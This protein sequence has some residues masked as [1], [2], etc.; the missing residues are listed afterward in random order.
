MN[1]LLHDFKF[2]SRLLAKSPSYTGIS[3]LVLVIGLALYLCVY[4]L[5]YNFEFKPLPFEGGDRFVGITTIAEQTDTGYFGNNFDGYAFNYF[6]ERLTTFEH[7]GAFDME[8]TALTDGDYARW[9]IGARIMPHLLQE[10]GVQPFMGRLLSEEDAIPGAKPVALLRYNIWKNYFAADPNIIG[11]TTSIGGIRHTIVGVMPKGFDYPNSLQVWLPLDI[12]N[13]PEPTAPTLHVIGKIKEGVSLTDANKELN[14]ILS[15]LI[16]EYPE[17]YVH[18]PTAEAISLPQAVMGSSGIRDLMSIVANFTLALAI[19]NLA[20]LLFVRALT[21]EKELAVRSAV[22]ASGFQIAKQIL[23]E[24]LLICMLG[25]VLSAVIADVALYY[26]ERVLTDLYNT[27]GVTNGLPSYVD[28]TIDWRAFLIAVSTTG[29][30][31]LAS[32]LWVAYRA[33]RIDSNSVL[34]ANGKGSNQPVNNWLVRAIIS[35]DVTVSCFL[36]IVCCLLVF[37]IV[38]SYQNDYGTSVENYFTAF[39]TLS[40]ERYPEAEQRLRFLENFHNELSYQAEFE[41]VTFTTTPPGRRGMQ[42]SFS[43]EDRDVSV[44]QHSPSNALVAIAPN[45]F[46]SLEIELLEG[47]SFSNGDDKNSLPVAII[48]EM[49]ANRLWPNESVLG[50]KLQLKLNGQEFSVTLV[51]TA[52]HAAQG[53]PYGEYDLKFPIVY[54]PIKQFTRNRFTVAVKLK[55]SVSYIQA[56]RALRESLKRLDREIALQA[57]LPLEFFTRFQLSFMTIP[58]QFAVAF[59]IATL[60]FAVIGIYGLIARSVMLRTTEVGVRKAVGATKLKILWIFIRQGLIYISLGVVIGG[61]AALIASN[62][63]TEYFTD[64][65]SEA[66]LAFTTVTLVIGALVLLASYLPARKAL[67]LEPGDALRDE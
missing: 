18:A 10:T 47:R 59:V 15:E 33:A 38:R 13:A 56:E 21:R 17:F 49:L 22:G 54:L 26:F 45:Y 9:F 12:G 19:L 3:V 39:I 35:I 67:A 53:T 64:I 32:G 11:T 46:D 34:A 6:N 55:P 4:S 61:A 57:P 24:S 51:G 25:L 27:G 36:L 31:W 16:N 65:L 37:S 29:F 42:A 23:L 30:I 28:L 43:L 63:L 14:Q 66:F 48:D 40:D 8:T 62:L 7:F 50:K 58:I 44:N 1:K 2:T 5:R 60:V 20:S 41:N 52:S